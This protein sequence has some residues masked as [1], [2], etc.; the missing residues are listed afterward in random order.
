MSRYLDA[1][2]RWSLS[3]VEAAALSAAPAPG[4]GW[5]VLRAAIIES[6]CRGILVAEVSRKGIL[7]RKQ[8][9]SVMPGPAA[10][11]ATRLLSAFVDPGKL[12]GSGASLD[13]VVDS[14]APLADD[15]VASAVYGQ[16][17]ARG[18]WSPRAVGRISETSQIKGVRETSE[19]EV[20]AAHLRETV[21]NLAEVVAACR[22]SG[23]RSHAALD[24]CRDSASRGDVRALVSELGASAMLV[25]GALA[26][27]DEVIKESL[28]HGL[29][30]HPVP[31]GRAAGSPGEADQAEQTGVG[32]LLDLRGIPGEEVPSPMARTV[33]ALDEWFAARA[34]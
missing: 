16:L 33:L 26:L 20:A 2:G 22:P 1:R 32:A 8:S 5:P 13:R 10:D 9:I 29:A 19:G 25:P 27:I 11:S 31:A 18:L 14:I 34:G 4:V 30:V 15:I 28:R 21:E 3:L 23:K 6:V 24:S 17:E 12:P 7:G